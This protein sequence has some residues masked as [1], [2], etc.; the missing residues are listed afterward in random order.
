MHKL[1]AKHRASAASIVSYGNETDFRVILRDV[2]ITEY[3]IAQAAWA[4]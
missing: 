4:S 1:I 3:G 2:V